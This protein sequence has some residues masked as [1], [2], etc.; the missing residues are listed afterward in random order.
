M[1]EKLKN[2]K[3]KKR[4]KLVA[5]FEQVSDQNVN[6]SSRSKKKM[7]IHAT[8]SGIWQAKGLNA[9]YVCIFLQKDEDCKTSSKLIAK[10]EVS[11]TMSSMTT[12]NMIEK[13]TT[14]MTTTTAT[15]A[16]T[17]QTHR[18]SALPLSSGYEALGIE[19]NR[20]ITYGL[21]THPA[22]LAN[23]P[24]R[25]ATAPTEATASSDRSCSDQRLNGCA[26]LTLA[27]ASTAVA[28]IVADTKI[29]GAPSEP[30]A[31]IS[32]SSIGITKLV[33]GSPP[34]TNSHDAAIVI[35]RRELI[36][37]TGDQE[38][39][40]SCH[41][42]GFRLGERMLSNTTSSVAGG[43]VVV[44]AEVMPHSLADRRNLKASWELIAV[45]GLPVSGSA[46][47]AEALIERA[48]CDNQLRLLVSPLP[49]LVLVDHGDYRINHNTTANNMQ[50]TRESPRSWA[51]N[52]RAR[53]M[54]GRQSAFAI[55][56]ETNDTVSTS[57][58]SNL[59]PK[60]A[61][62]RTSTVS[63]Q[64]VSSMEG[65]EFIPI[66]RQAETAAAQ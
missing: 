10:P 52:G 30:D 34:L 53:E 36:E 16:A 11:K 56:R 8:R 41:S 35:D 29:D 61:G 58:C 21:R 65:R 48:T 7:F 33:G 15:S 45:N 51:S 2:R 66:D 19:E 17:K 37:L 5:S 55:K 26:T 6:K 62:S 32:Q 28:K 59:G 27:P 44:V 12:T 40:F 46:R 4:A 49:Q 24:S 60:H 13:S 39:K 47:R 20:D 9:Y 38:V 42:L 63:K 22:I 64:L 25:L 1:R 23:L 14:M 3:S 43:Q 50:A 54:N 57:T 31:T 18:P